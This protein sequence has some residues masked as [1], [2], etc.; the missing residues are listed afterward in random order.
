ME[1]NGGGDHEG[2]AKLTGSYEVP[3]PA[4]LDRADAQ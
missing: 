1:P 2:P 3:E 4:E